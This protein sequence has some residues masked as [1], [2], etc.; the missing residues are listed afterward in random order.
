MGQFEPWAI[1]PVAQEYAHGATM[2]RLRRDIGRRLNYIPRL[3]GH[4]KNRRQLGQSVGAALR[5]ARIRMR[6][7]R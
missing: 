2:E 1:L 7:S 6:Q 4:F 3:I 5:S